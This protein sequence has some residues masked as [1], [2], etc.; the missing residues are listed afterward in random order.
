MDLRWLKQNFGDRIIFWGGAISTQRTFPFGT[1][2]QVARE[3]K[4]VLDIMTPGGGFVVNPIHNILPEVPVENI[5][6]LY[7]T[8]YAYRYPSSGGA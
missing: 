4:E 2:D 7:R 3:A 8:A 1:P 6:A 5:I